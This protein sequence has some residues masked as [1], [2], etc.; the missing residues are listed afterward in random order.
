M[1][2]EELRYAPTAEQ[3]AVMYAKPHDHRIYGRGHDERVKATIALAREHLLQFQSIADLSCGNGTIVRSLTPHPHDRWLGD[4]APLTDVRDGEHIL[5]GDIF[6]TL[7]EIP[8][9]THVFVLS[10]TL[11][12]VPEPLELLAQIRQR[13]LQLVLSTPMEAWEDTNPEH[14][15]AWDRDG[16]EDFAQVAGWSP[17]AFTSVDSRAWGEPYLYGIWIMR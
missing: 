5:H 3:L 16:V 2:V 13:C 10:E 9:P 1:R 15:W 14:L 11:E 12:H 6:A 7:R 4:F 17:V 8:D